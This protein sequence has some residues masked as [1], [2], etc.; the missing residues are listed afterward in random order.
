MMTTHIHLSSQPAIRFSFAKTPD[1][2]FSCF[3]LN[4]VVVGATRTTVPYIMDV[5]HIIYEQNIR[6][7]MDLST[8]TRVN[9]KYKKAKPYNKHIF[10]SSCL[11]SPRSQRSSVQFSYVS[12]PIIH[13]Y[14]HLKIIFSFVFFWVFNI[15]LYSHKLLTH[16]RNTIKM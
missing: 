13:P 7:N 5:Y 16:K 9:V 11:A 4:L 15:K 8:R 10:H 3:L 6:P 2:P 12:R 14:I 1:Y